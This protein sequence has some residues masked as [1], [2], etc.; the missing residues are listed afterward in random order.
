MKLCVTLA[1]FNEEKNLA[2]CLEAVKDIADEIVIVDGTSTDKTRDI[3][4]SFGAKITMVLNRP[5]NF[6]IN[7][8]K[9]L[10][11]SK[12]EWILQLD[13]DEVVSS[14]LAKEIIKV[15]NM[16]PVSL[17]K[18]QNTLL[19]K[20]LFLRHQ[21]VVEQRDGKIGSDSGPYTAFFIPRLN[22]FLGKFIR[23]GGIYPDG[24]IR[25]VKN[26]HAHFPQKSVHEQIKIDGRV[27]WLTNNLLHYGNPSF[28]TYLEKRFNRYT[29]IMAVSLSGGFIENV[30]WRPLFDKYQGFFFI[31]FRHLGFLDGFP[32]FVWALFS[33]LHFP[34]AYFKKMEKKYGARSTH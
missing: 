22:F 31:Y 5:E 19:N 8:E 14:D 3:A 12:S 11:L 27:G 25:L 15:V 10:R 33:A 1:T 23:H 21:L 28:S 17:E 13:A 26:G 24:V 2:R 34:I 4:K 29:N 9:A 7:K 16:D 20:E 6:H 30:I 18:Y 32:G